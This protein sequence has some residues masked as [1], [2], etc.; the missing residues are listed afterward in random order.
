MILR[1]LPAAFL[2]ASLL[3]MPAAAAASTAPSVHIRQVELGDFPTVS[4]TVSIEGV[5]TPE[6]IGATENGKPI[7]DVTVRSLSEEGREIDV[8]LA[9]D[10]SDSVRGEP[11]AAAVAAARG[12]VDRLPLDVPIGVLTFSDLPRVVQPVTTDHA[13]VLLALDSLTETQRGT[14]LFDGVA[15]GA[16]LFAGPAQHNIILLTDGSDVDSRNDLEATVLTA[17]ENHVT[18]FTVGL[19][20]EPE[21][22]VLKALATRTGGTYTA[23]VQA[24]LPTIYQNLA[25][26][27]SHQYVLRYQSVSSPGSQVSI[28]VTSSAGTDSSLVL[29]PRPPATLGPASGPGKAL[30][31]GTW[32]LILVLAFSFLGC[33]LLLQ[34]LLGARTRMRREQDLARR[35]G[36]SRG[37]E[38]DSEEGDSQTITGWIPEPFVAAAE[39][40][41][42]AGGFSSSLARQLERG[43]VP[44]R[45]GEFVAGAAFAGLVGAMIG[46]ILLQSVL[47]ALV[48]GAASAVAPFVWIQMKVTRRLNQF[49]SQLPDILMILASSMRAG[50]SFL[51]A[52]DMVAKEIGD[53][54]AP[55]FARLV[56]EV[57]L[58]RPVEEAMLALAERVGTDEFKWAVIG[59]NVQRE[60]GGNLAEILDT[61]ADTVRERDSVRRQ[62][63]V[64]SAEGRLSMRILIVIPFAL[65]LY[66]VKV[67]PDYMRLLWS[68]R[69]GWVMIGI[70]ACLMTVGVFWARKVVKIDV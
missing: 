58:G 68:T 53:P 48:F 27:L 14:A 44:I 7:S 35:M 28:S 2:F 21:D 62:I 20:T 54:A 32:G 56:A 39:Q 42:E 40:L 70:A 10:T 8:V 22:S 23:A 41:V 4:V 30:L 65:S 1:K 5:V 6:D 60:V 17:Q 33:F 37:D 25:A 26:Q 61:V 55:E 29:M 57:R 49:H 13:A 9:V 59:V 36:V 50:H 18:V 45:A 46:G 12:F 31:N 11:L 67:N 3:V 34:M 64:L 19:G 43:G 51:Q 15:L 52:L 69:L 24:E 66:M 38:P 63:K 47:F 16:T